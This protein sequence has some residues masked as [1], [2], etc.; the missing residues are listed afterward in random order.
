MRVYAVDKP[1]L[2]QLWARLERR[3]RD[4]PRP[5]AAQGA[6]FLRSIDA[7]KR[8]YFSHPESAPLLY[9][10]LWLGRDLARTDL[11]RILEFTALLYFYIRI[12]DDVLDEPAQRGQPE[13]LLL[14][15]LMFWDGFR[16]L[17]DWLR[18][19][20]FSRRSRRAWC[21][22]SAATECERRCLGR[23]LRT[24][25]D[26]IY[27]DRNFVAHARKVAMAEIP[28]YAVLSRRR[29]WEAVEHIPKLIHLLGQAYGLTN[30]VDG[31]ERDLQAGMNTYLLAQVRADLPFSRRHD[32]HA[33][34]DALHRSPYREK[35]MLRAARLLERTR[36]P[37]LALG[38][39]TIDDFITERVQ[40]LQQAAV[41][42]ALVR[43]GLALSPR[44]V[45]SKL[46]KQT[47]WQMN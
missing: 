2:H 39:D 22:Y 47:V 34:R 42:F 30:D 4:Y 28:L 13:W 29:R 18:D 27:S 11:L 12:Q 21:A 3:I 38:M 43:L 10:P 36:E 25:R 35:F 32:H 14:G 1:L 16:V 45:A 37:A 19:P 26:A 9:L 20:E 7:G 46:A 8:I 31:S 17:D 40:R 15:N 24:R 5:I 44:R 6:A 41:D 33:I 23:R